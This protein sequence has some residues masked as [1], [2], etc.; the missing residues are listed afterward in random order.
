[1]QK[2]A[3]GISQEIWGSNQETGRFD[4]KLGD[5]RENRES[6][7]VCMRELACGSFCSAV[8]FVTVASQLCN[9]WKASLSQNNSQLVSA[10]NYFQKFRT[11]HMIPKSPRASTVSGTGNI[12]LSRDTTGILP[13]S[14]SISSFAYSRNSS[15]RAVSSAFFLISAS[16]KM[17]EGNTLLNL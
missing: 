6:R 17:K 7:Q 8:Q 13:S 10:N 12:T 11:S 1:M 4:E 15:A 3:V 5:S 16:I 2:A 9:S 14:M